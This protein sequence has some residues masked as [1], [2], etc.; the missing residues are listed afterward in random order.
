M[1]QIDMDMPRNC[2]EC[3]LQSVHNNFACSA[4][5]NFMNTAFFTNCRPEWCPLSGG[6]EDRSTL[7]CVK[8][9]LANYAK[10]HGCLPKEMIVNEATL[11]KMEDEAKQKVA[12]QDRPYIMPRYCGVNIKTVDDDAVILTKTS[13]ETVK[14]TLMEG[15]EQE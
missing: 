8:G 12:L 14:Y 3:Q 2:Y 10:K 9:I 6:D 15:V 5:R 4:I 11:H 13:G 1:I 7:G